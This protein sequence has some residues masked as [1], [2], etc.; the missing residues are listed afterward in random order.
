MGSVM[1]P[2]CRLLPMLVALLFFDGFTAFR[3]GDGRYVQIYS[4]VVLLSLVSE[5][6]VTRFQSGFRRSMSRF[7]LPLTPYFNTK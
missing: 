2:H 5:H 6:E 4:E 1:A 7:K 3:N